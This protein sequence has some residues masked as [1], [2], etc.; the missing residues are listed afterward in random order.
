MIGG[1]SMVIAG[2]SSM[3]VA[4]GSSI[5]GSSAVFGDAMDD[6][7]A[8]ELGVAVGLAAGTWLL[9]MASA[10]GRYHA[11]T[12]G[13]IVAVLSP[14]RNARSVF[15]FFAAAVSDATTAT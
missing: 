15:R 12:A 13:D 4:G 5:G 9:K 1:S 2:G 8:T 7:V 14:M 3:V 11:S 10:W 6:D